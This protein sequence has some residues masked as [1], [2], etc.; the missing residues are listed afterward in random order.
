MVG[1]VLPGSTAA[2]CTAPLLVPAHVYGWQ[3]SGD[4]VAG[5]GELWGG[6][7]STWACGAAC[8]PPPRSPPAAAAC[9]LLHLWP[10]TCLPGLPTALTMMLGAFG[11]QGGACHAPRQQP[12][13]MGV[14][15]RRRRRAAAVPP[16]LIGR[17]SPC[18]APHASLPTCPPLPA[19]T[20]TSH[21]MSSADP[22][23]TTSGGH[24]HLHSPPT[25]LLALP[26]TRGHCLGGGQGG[27]KPA[28]PLHACQ[29]DT[30]M[31]AP[32]T[33]SCMGGCWSCQGTT[34]LACPT[35]PSLPQT[36]PFPKKP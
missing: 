15:R 16:L 6:W 3:G 13:P 27:L 36:A 14:C 7:Q 5:P 32:P 30:P 29:L 34:P 21:T 8:G 26:C 35:P 33:N 18:P 10:T 28:T 20:H 11:G 9:M 12:C 24:M 2:A 4:A 17:L 19:G 31:H 22:S 23:T 1:P 25:C